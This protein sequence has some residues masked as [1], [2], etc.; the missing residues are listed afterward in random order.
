MRHFFH[1][2]AT[3]AAQFTFKGMLNTILQSIENFVRRKMLHLWIHGLKFPTHPR[4]A[5][6]P[7]YAFSATKPIKDFV[8]SRPLGVTVFWAPKTAGKSFSLMRLTQGAERHLFVC[9]DH[10]TFRS[11]D[12]VVPFLYGRLGQKDCSDCLLS[13]LLPTDAFITIVLENFDNAMRHGAA[14]AIELITE[15][16]IDS[17]ASGAYNV[18][19]VLNNPHNAH[20]LLRGHSLQHTRLLGPPFCGMWTRADLA[21]H[22]VH[23]DV[24]DAID[25]CG[26]LLPLSHHSLKSP[27][28]QLKMA[29]LCVEWDTGER[30]LAGY[31]ETDA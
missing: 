24:L 18:L 23:P 1:A 28:L 26:T 25:F 20:L 4:L 16:G 17:L 3:Q 30:L 15:L 5:H 31:R 11:G 22:A 14:E 2:I 9:I 13:A 19:V 10:V 27:L 29:Q 8:V 7:C 6:S 21:K 12:K